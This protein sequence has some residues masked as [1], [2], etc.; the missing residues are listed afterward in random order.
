LAEVAGEEDE[1]RVGCRTLDL[2]EP[3]EADDLGVSGGD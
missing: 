2:A 1:G 3:G